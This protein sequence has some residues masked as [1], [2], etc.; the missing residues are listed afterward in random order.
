MFVGAGLGGGTALQFSPEFKPGGAI[1]LDGQFGGGASHYLT[2]AVDLDLGIH[3]WDDQNHWFINPGPEANFFIT[4]SVFIRAGIGLPIT[5]M[6]SDS[7]DKTDTTVGFDA[8]VGVGFEFFTGASYAVALALELDYMLLYQGNDVLAV[9]FSMG[10][11]Y[12]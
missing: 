8:G 4:K 3:I 6:N 1:L 10:L 12:Y 5:F 11:R 2:L 7:T 9:G